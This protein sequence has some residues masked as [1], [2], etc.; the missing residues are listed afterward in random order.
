MTMNS[1]SQS[2]VHILSAEQSR[3]LLEAYQRVP[4]SAAPRNM[5]RQ[6]ATRISN[7]TDVKTAFLKRVG[8]TWE[9]LAESH[10]HPRLPAAGAAAWKMFDRISAALEDGVEVYSDERLDWTIV[11]LASGAGLP[12]VFVLEG[13]W[14][15]SA[16][17]LR[18]WVQNLAFAEP[19][20]RLPSSARIRVA[21]HRLTRKLGRVTGVREVCTVV[22]R[23]VVRAV[24]SRL[25]TF[26]VPAE[27]NQL[28][29][30][31]THG[32]PVELVE[33]VR[34]APGS[35]VIGSVYQNRA[36]LCVADVTV[37]PGLQRRRPRYR[38]NSF[39]ALPIL[40]G[41][42]VLGVVC[43]TDRLDNHAYTR[44]DVSV[45]RALTA[46]A[47]LALAR[48]RAQ[49]QAEAFA[50]AA[51]IDP[52]SG[53]FNRRYFHRRLE[54]ELQR[55]QRHKTPVALLMVD[56]DDFKTINDRFGHMAGD[57]VIRGVSE[58][59]RRSV[60][61]F[62]LCTRFGGEEFAIVMPGSSPENSA[63]IAERIRQ[64]IEEYKPD[65]PE[66]KGVRVTASFGL[67]VSQDMAPRE[68]IDRADQALYMAKRAGKNRVVGLHRPTSDETGP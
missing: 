6:L 5:L 43:M 62:D 19:A 56:I 53:L 4:L 2:N 10:P 46:P 44:H 48:E 51:V 15:L 32:Y 13:D 11:G 39:V 33:A 28:A 20:S 58:I 65:E 50:H 67:S 3:L 35:G 29:I 21:T 68:L 31:A 47:A 55:A 36:P 26:A 24:P 23:H 57:T 8:G 66:L 27:E 38:T 40:A 7:I 49:R 61:T 64:R 37:L 54:E 34:I 45:L 60:R 18:Q 1:S 14:T 41:S 63:S 22:L 9:I 59:L 16:Q 42:N 25:A 52:L 12:V 17:T 30:V